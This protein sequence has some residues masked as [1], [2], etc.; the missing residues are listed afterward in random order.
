MDETL[1]SYRAKSI[2]E[3]LSNQD[4]S[5]RYWKTLGWRCIKVEITIKPI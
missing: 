3:F 2:K 1:N 4:K 5:W